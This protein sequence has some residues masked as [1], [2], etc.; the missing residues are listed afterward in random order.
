MQI[1]FGVVV[2]EAR[3]ARNARRILQY[4]LDNLNQGQDTTVESVIRSALFSVWHL[5]VVCVACFEC[6]CTL[7]KSNP[8]ST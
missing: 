2:K 3:T 5:S 8:F 6:L 1:E 4:L 7:V